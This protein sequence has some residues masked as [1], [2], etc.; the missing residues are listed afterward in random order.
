[1]KTAEDIKHG[2]IYYAEFDKYIGSEICGTRPVLVLQN[3]IGN[4]HS[5]TIIVAGISS[6]IKKMYLPTHV[7]IDEECGLKKKSVILL[8][9][10]HTIDRKRL[11]GYVGTLSNTTMKRVNRAIKISLG[12]VG[13]KQNAGEQNEV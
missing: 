10:I 7:L 9:Q 5:P 11:C 12:M 6:H 1:M 13:S 8:E 4:T 2:D 3:D